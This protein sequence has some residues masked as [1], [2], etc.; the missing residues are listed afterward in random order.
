MSN[1]KEMPTCAFC[2]GVIAFPPYKE[3][4]EGKTLSFHAKPCADEYRKRKVSQ[5]PMR[6]AFCGG[7]IVYEPYKETVEGK[8]LLF[9]AKACAD[10]LKETSEPLP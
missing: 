2:G 8:E 1:P 10:A 5:P 6:C 4:V 3:V 7:L 9:H